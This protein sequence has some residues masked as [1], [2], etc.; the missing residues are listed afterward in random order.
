MAYSYD[1][2]FAVDPN[3]PSNVARNASILIFDPNDATKTPV[4][5]TDVTG[6]HVANP[7]TVNQHGFGPAIKH[8][9][10]DRLAWEGAGMSGVFT[11]YEGMKEEAVAARVAAQ[12]AATTAA[13]EASAG[14]A[15]VVAD[16]E[17]AATSAAASATAA[18]QSAALVN[19]P[20][21][22]AIAAAIRS[23]RRTVAAAPASMAA[24]CAATLAATA[25][26]FMPS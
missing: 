13:A 21:D 7:I 19:A 5:L 17:T 8:E 25:S 16:A 9:T 3:S 12:A 14:V 23:S 24:V 22:T 20:A 15:S 2:I 26:S 11:S 6:S 4:T 10:L 1:P 18:A